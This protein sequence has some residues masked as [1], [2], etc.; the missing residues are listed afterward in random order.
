VQSLIKRL[1]HDNSAATVV[2]YGLIVGIISV[3]LIVG[4]QSFSNQ[5]SILYQIVNTYTAAA[6]A[7]N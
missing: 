3:S 1:L 4:M 2:E 5:L 7:K 6:A